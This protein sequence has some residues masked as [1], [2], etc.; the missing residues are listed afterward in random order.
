ML[1]EVLL[2]E[3]EDMLCQIVTDFPTGTF[4]VAHAVRLIFAQY[5]IAML[6]MR[7]RSTSIAFQPSPPRKVKF[8]LLTGSVSKPV[9]WVS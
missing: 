2:Q 1:C 3:E 4:Q 7:T 5:R 9:C 8:G 6:L